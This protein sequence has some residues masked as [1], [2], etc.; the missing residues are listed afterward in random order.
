MDQI[1]KE[2]AQDMKDR[3]SCATTPKLGLAARG[4]HH[5][6]GELKRDWAA[7]ARFWSLSLSLESSCFVPSSTAM[8]AGVFQPLLAFPSAQQ[9][10]QEKRAYCFSWDVGRYSIWLSPLS[11]TNRS[12][13]HFRR[14]WQI[15]T[16]GLGLGSSVATCDPLVAHVLLYLI[17]TSLYLQRYIA[18]KIE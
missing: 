7:S 9:C 3:Y 8:T 10:P 4:C 15:Q 12:N 6:F 2:Y 1:R 18:G 17:I 16:V 14:S 11:S 13:Q 5:E